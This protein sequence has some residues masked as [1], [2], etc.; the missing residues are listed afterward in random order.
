MQEVKPRESPDPLAVS[1]DRVTRREGVVAG[2]RQRVYVTHAQAEVRRAAQWV[3]VINQGSPVTTGRPE[4][5]LPHPE[6]LGWSNAAG[7]I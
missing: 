7:S 5:A 2:G 3:V 6:T 4:E 1:G